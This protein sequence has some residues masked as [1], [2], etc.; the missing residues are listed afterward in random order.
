MKK[1]YST[2]MM[3]AMMVAALGFTACGSD[4]EDDEVSEA[5]I[6]G[7]WE[8]T[9]FDYHSISGDDDVDE[10]IKVGEKIYFHSDG[11]FSE[12]GDQGTWRLKGN[13][14]TVIVDDEYYLP[15]VYTVSKLTSSE[16]ILKIDYG[17]FNAT[18]KF[19]RVSN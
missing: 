13:Q 1:V 7:V 10:G 8:C 5:S 16:L 11:T 6:V 3:L 14:L 19:K 18:I 9:A 4:D 2:I 12:S 15:V 17:V